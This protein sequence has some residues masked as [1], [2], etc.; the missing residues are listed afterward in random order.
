MILFTGIGSWVS[1]LVPVESHPGWIY[2]I[3]L[4]IAATILGITLSMQNVIDNTIRMSI[5]PRCLI[6]IALTFPVSFMLG[7]CFPTGMRL[8]GR[9]SEGAL[10]WMWGINGA[11]G[12]F[13]S[14]L[15]VAL[16]IWAGIHGSLYLA[17]I[18]Y[19]ALVIPAN[20]LCRSSALQTAVASE[21][22]PLLRL[23]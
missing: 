20:W 3:A 22:A 23:A 16:S 19:A 8:V 18:C 21:I 7:F 5:L 11:W 2:A 14:I 1:D 9:L 13:S 6:V 10:P 17:A 4:A 15:A 12:V